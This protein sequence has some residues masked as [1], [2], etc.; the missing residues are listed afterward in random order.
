MAATVANME[1][2]KILQDANTVASY[3]IEEKGF[4]VCMVSKP[5]AA[6]SSKAAP[7]TPAP[8]P[9]QTPAAPAAPAPSSNTQ[10]APATPSPAPAQASGERFNDPS[11]LT[12]GGDREAAIADMESMGFARADID[13]AMRAAFFNP[14]RAV[15][16]LLTV[17]QATPLPNQTGSNLI[18]GYSRERTS[19]ASTSPSPNLA[20][21]CYRR[22][23]RCDRCACRKRS[24]RR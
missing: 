18:L 14:D 21:A 22:Q 3:S 6:P 20:Y 2:G 8:A 10:N 13:V 17:R 5:K 7:S 15:E 1:I 19:R 11:A 24:L 16:Y 9:A 12:M 23:H 4:I